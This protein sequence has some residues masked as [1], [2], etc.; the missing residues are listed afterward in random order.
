MEQHPVPRNIS[1]FEFH[2]VGDM[3]LRQFGYVAGGGIL[4]FIIFK[5]APFPAII[6]FP[7][8]GITAFIGIAFAF[9][10]I[11]ER[12]LD[13]WLVA[14]IKSVYAPSQYL[15]KK[16]NPTPEILAR[17]SFITTIST[18]QQQIA[19]QNEAKEK[20]RAY[21]ATIPA[22]PHQVLNLREQSYINKTLSYFN[23]ASTAT[24]IE[25]PPKQPIPIIPQPVNVIQTQPITL[26]P[27][28]PEKKETLQSVSE[29]VIQIQPVASV[30]PPVTDE[31]LSLKKQLGELAAEKEKL[32][33]ELTM[34][35]TAQEKINQP[36]VVKLQQAQEVKKPTIQTVTPQIAVNEVG[37]TNLSQIPNLVMGI[38]KD[39]QKR[40]LPNIILTI[41]D[42]KGVPIRAVKT[43]KLGQF[44]TAT[45][46][47]NGTYLLEIEDPLK[48]Y[49]FDIAE[50]TLSGKVFQPIVIFAKGEKELNREKLNKELFGNVN[51]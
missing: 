40:F 27:E 43:N 51:M 28:K 33:K 11:Q 19:S 8:V 7:L 3:T 14:F 46:L 10:P 34:L 18:P 13:R 44:A 37:L 15:W 4:A 29:A 12:P 32:T 6:K 16:T 9:L 24:S 36:E 26:I 1:S 47:P 42:I 2:L 48:R 45:S 21:M 17:I 38:V 41:K 49:V 50:I 39:G 25:Q 20:L 22:A 35:K 5:I 23:T 31:Y 30:A